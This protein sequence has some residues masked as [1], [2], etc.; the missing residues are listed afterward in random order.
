MTATLHGR[1]L[2]S[3][4]VRETTNLAKARA[5]RD[6]GR[7]ANSIGSSVTDTPA[8]VRGVVGTRVKYALP[9]HEGAEA[10]KIRPRNPGGTLKFYWARVGAVVYFKSVNHPGV[11][12]TPFLTSSLADAARPLGF[13]VVRQVTDGEEYL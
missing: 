12:A 4:V 11:G 13:V 8:R 3:R 1:A 7:L 10:H 5:P 6:T 9:I 2:V